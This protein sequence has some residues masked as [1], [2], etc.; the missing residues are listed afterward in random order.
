MKNLTIYLVVIVLFYSCN[1][2]NKD[3]VSY[4]TTN[5][6]TE[7][8]KHPGK[9][10]ME[11]NCYVCHSP[12]A[13]HDDRIGPPMVAVKRHY[14]NKSTTKE[15]FIKDMQAW[16]KNPN[17]EDA[18]MYGAVKRF[19]VM[20]KQAFP[21]ETIEKIADY[22]FDN[23][24]E[25]PE[26]FEEHFQEERGNGN[27]KG[28]G[29][30]MGKGKGMQHGKQQTAIDANEL[31]FEERGLKYALGTKAELGKNLMGKIQKEG[32]TA[33]ITFCNEKAYPLTDSM[34]I[35]YNASIKRVSDKPR[36][37]NNKANSK[38][39]K[40]I[41]NYKTVIAKGEEVQP[42]TEIIEDK[43]HVYYPIVTNSMCLQCHGKPKANITQVDYKVIKGLYPKDMA[44]GYGEN[45]VRG[46]W[47][48]ELDN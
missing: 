10:L 41:E 27:G 33:A 38:E 8:S 44:I 28:K 18:R 19:G 48:V 37:E 39:I 23:T 2:K 34:A 12:T 22:M 31:S 13:S 7:Q 32:T 26:W 45:E 47:H 9:K 14:I 40:Y 46:I 11:T 5:E 4:A 17:A 15:E 16:I 21:E 3:T 35:V 42:I 25:Q 1:S 6:N 43:V 30:G 20:P 29:S 24:I 36:N